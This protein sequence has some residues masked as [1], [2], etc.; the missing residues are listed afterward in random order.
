MLASQDLSIII[1]A[2]V[3]RTE[4][5]IMKNFFIELAIS[6]YLTDNY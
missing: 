5:G 6:V 3:I 2:M 1:K 4:R